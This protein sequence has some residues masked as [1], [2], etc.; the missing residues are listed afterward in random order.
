MKHIVYI[1]KS[2][3]QKER[4]WVKTVAQVVGGYI[5]TVSNTPVCHGSPKRGEL[6]FVAHEEITDYQYNDGTK[7]TDNCACKKR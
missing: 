3:N 6:V 5:G 1:K 4:M 2:F 7:A